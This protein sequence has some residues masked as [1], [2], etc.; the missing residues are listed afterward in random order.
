MRRSRLLALIPAVA[1][2]VATTA[3][4][5]P[6]RRIGV[7]VSTT[8]GVED[9]DSSRLSDDLA[10]ALGGAL[11]VDTISG[12]EVKRRMPPEGIPAE[13]VGDAACRNDLGRR[14][15]ADELL[16]LAIVKVGDRINIDAT[17]ADVASGRSA[18]RPRLTLSP[19][20]D[21]RSRFAEI[22][23]RYLPHIRKEKEPEARIIMVPAEAVERDDGR[24]IT[25]PVIIAGG[26]AAAAG[27]TGAIFALAARSRFDELDS[28]GCRETRTCD[29]GLVDS[30]K[31]RAL[32]ADLFFAGAV[33]AGATAAVLYYLS[34]PD[35]PREPRVSVTGGAGHLGVSLGGR[36]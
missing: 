25:L 16:L 24:R 34:G 31:N 36:F 6:Q 4:A 2:A 19:G 11:P 29:Q 35:E 27:V 28:S 22:A 3:E 1:A 5:G 30:G 15:D 32:A 17:W 21:A 9:G 20:D 7:I 26:T 18:S 12:A 13:C 10:A 33:A 14:L 8:V 23:P